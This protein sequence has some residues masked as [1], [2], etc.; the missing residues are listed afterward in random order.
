MILYLVNPEVNVT[1][2]K[3]TASHSEAHPERIPQVSPKEL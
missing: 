2:Y 3:L 1:Q